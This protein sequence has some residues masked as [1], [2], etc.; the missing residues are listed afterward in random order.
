MRS[1]KIN[2]ALLTG[3]KGFV[4]SHL[5]PKLVASGIKVTLLDRQQGQDL[6]EASSFQDL[7]RQD[8]VIHLAATTFVPKS[9]E[10]PGET[11]YN[12]IVS[13]LRVLEFCRREGVKKII[14]MSSYVYGVPH[15]L[16]V[17]EAH[18]ALI[19]NPYGRSKVICEK[20]VLSYFEDYGICPVV[21]RPFNIYGPGQ[22]SVF[23]VPSI[24]RQILESPQLEVKSTH[25][26]RDYVFV[27][28][29][30]EAI[31]AV[32]EKYPF[33]QPEI[34]NVGTGKSY[35]IA[36]VISV[37]Q[38]LAKTNKPVVVQS[39]GT[40]D[41]IEDCVADIRHIQNSLGWTPRFSLEAGLNRMLS[42]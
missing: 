27:E 42:K 35:S 32:I 37:A 20:L 31:L 14:F 18:P 7:G 5:Y 30:V 22:A 34:F 29:V 4:G 40:V 16:P 12:N 24:I 17:K 26:K 3:S 41:P 2:T 25:H 11:Y 8:L 15:A 23:A 10:V 1:E 33:D 21:L 9:T 28:D 38:R 6:T 13:T 36:E 19:M 39:S